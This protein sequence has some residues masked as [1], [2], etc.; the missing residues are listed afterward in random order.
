MTVIQPLLLVRALTLKTFKCNPFKLKMLPH[1]HEHQTCV[2]KDGMFIIHPG[3][4]AIP[5][6][7]T[8]YSTYIC[9]CKYISNEAIQMKCSPD[10]NINSRNLKI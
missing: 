5:L 10:M 9:F 7:D 3:R 2:K 6:Q 1:T 4:G 8:M